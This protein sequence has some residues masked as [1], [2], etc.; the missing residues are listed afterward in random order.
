MADFK[1][2]TEELQTSSNLIMEKM[3]SYNVKWQNIHRS[4]RTCGCQL[5]R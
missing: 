4:T 5:A 3:G 1:V 2:T